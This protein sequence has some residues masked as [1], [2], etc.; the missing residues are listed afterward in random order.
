MKKLL[1]TAALFALAGLPSLVSAQDVKPDAAEGKN[2]KPEKKEMQEII[3]RNKNGKDMNLKVE[4]NGD[5]VTVN[6]KPLSEFK[7]D[8]VTIN[9]RRMT[10]RGRDQG[11]VYNFGDDAMAFNM[12]RDFLKEWKGKE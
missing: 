10:T 5:N 6:G 8:G 1:F 4:I 11:M 2:E 7:E 9:K 12:D 3:I